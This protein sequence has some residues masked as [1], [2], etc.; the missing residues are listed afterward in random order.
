M[1]SGKN[2]VIVLCLLAASGLYFMPAADGLPG[3]YI[4]TQRW[5]DLLARNS[6]LVN[7]AYLTEENCISFRACEALVLDNT[8]NLTEAGITVP[9]GLYRSFGVTYAG[10]GA[11][12]PL[13]MRQWRQDNS[14]AMDSLGNGSNRDNLFML[15]YADNLWGRLSIGMNLSVS[16]QTL[17]GSPRF[18][19]AGDFGL[20]YRLLLAPVTGEHLVGISFQNILQPLTDLLPASGQF[21]SQGY[22][23][24]VKLSWNAYWWD[25]QVDAGVDVD[26]KNVYGSLVKLQGEKSAASVEYGAAARLGF[27]LFRMINAYAQ[28]G[29]DYWAGTFGINFPQINFGRDFSVLYQYT[30][31]M[32]SEDVNVQSV[33]F[34]MDLGPHREESYALRM[35]MQ[36]NVAPNELYNK[37]MR[38]YMAQNYWDAFFVFSQLFAQYPVFV[39]NDMVTYFRGACLEKMDM[40]ESAAGYYRETVRQYAASEI[41]SHADLGLMRIYYR[42]GNSS[43]VAGQ[44]KRIISSSAPDSLKYHAYYL[45]AQVRMK[46]KDYANAINLFSRIP[47][48]HTEYVFAQ[49]SCAIAAL[50][51]GRRDDAIDYLAVCIGVEAQNAAQKECINRSYLYLGYIFYENLELPKA[52]TALRSIPATSYYYE[53]ALLAMCWTALKAKQWDACIDYG[54][55]LQ[56]VSSKPL[57]RCDAMLIA[58]YSFLMQKKYQ[59]AGALLKKADA[60]ITSFRTPDPD[61]LAAAR[62]TGGKVRAAY[63]DIA[64][65]T[66]RISVAAQTSGTIARID[67]LH[68]IQQEDKSMLD[69]LAVY[70]DEF[71][72]LSL[73]AR[74]AEAVKSDIA[75]TSAIAQKFNREAG[76]IEEQEKMQGKQ[77]KIDEKI[78][79]MKKELEKLNS[80][81]R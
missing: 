74:N 45:M 3:E 26:C 1:W 27:W 30:N 54:Q 69:K 17:F 29:S 19:I 57:L 46:E 11:T 34:R 32:Q 10:E 22:S 59:E 40:R 58:G 78:E 73:F 49:H 50:E 20:S 81:G 41:A 68:K 31:V 21:T 62:K 63:D 65:G 75:F 15:S 53:D 4:S 66:D 8:F 47:R 14:G 25:R 64:R 52:I 24:N 33:Y 48:H 38:L 42:D 55:T 35:A 61:S 56:K 6:A 70:A 7:P 51:T 13:A 79:Q 72:R 37:A 28:F 43:L 9:V 44:F 77:N 12:L 71:S 36:W 18:G 60:L 80:G 67:S 16:Y 23:N 76:A 2:P 39:K 5:R